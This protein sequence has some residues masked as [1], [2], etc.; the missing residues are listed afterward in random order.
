MEH[1]KQTNK[2]KR[3]DLPYRNFPVEE[4]NK[5]I[6]SGNK[7]SVKS[8]VLRGDGTC[9]GTLCYKKW[10]GK[11]MSKGCIWAEIWKMWKSKTWLYYEMSISSKRGSWCTSART[12]KDLECLGNDLAR[13]PEMVWI[14]RDEAR[15]LAGTTN[16]TVG[17]LAYTE[18]VGAE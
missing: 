8:K 16:T 15:K 10:W 7:G 1:K 3:K 6:L 9:L 4:E 14:D 2:Q 17:N 12:R 5:Y 11:T 18:C 13:Q